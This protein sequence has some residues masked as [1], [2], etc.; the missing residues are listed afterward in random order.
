MQLNQ[1]EIYLYKSQYVRHVFWLRFTQIKIGHFLLL[2]FF[3]FLTSPLYVKRSKTCFFIRFPEYYPPLS[4]LGFCWMRLACSS[5]P[6]DV[7]LTIVMVLLFI[8]SGIY[9]PLGE[10]VGYHNNV[11]FFYDCGANSSRPFD[12]T[13]WRTVIIRS[14]WC[15][16]I[17]GV[18]YIS[19]GSK[20]YRNV[21]IFYWN[22]FVWRHFL[23][24]N[25]EDVYIHVKCCFKNNILAF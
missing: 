19:V 10:G 5:W 11:F 24:N 13:S 2:L 12:F 8:N 9:L 25:V 22:V 14:C 18:F 6:R 23:Q 20:H 1:C 15:I 3:P 21:C 4:S 16:H 7:H 17:Y